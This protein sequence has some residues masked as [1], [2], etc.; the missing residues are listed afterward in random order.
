M[1]PQAAQDATILMVDDEPVNLQLLEQLLRGAGYT[2]VTSTTDP[3]RM[4]E[5]YHQLA[6][7]LVMLD[8]RMPH[9]DGFAVMR[10]LRL[11]QPQGSYL[12]ILMLT[13]E[14]STESKQRALS[15]GA[16]DFLHK[17]FDPVEVLLRI[18]NL[19][20]T[21]R[22]HTDLRLDNDLLE[23][24]IRERTAEIERARADLAQIAHAAAHE[25]VEPV[26]TV[27]IN[28]QFLAQ[29]LGQGLDGDAAQCL[30]YIVEGSTRAY[31]LLGDLLAI[32]EANATHADVAR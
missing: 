6:P 30:R 29:R 32:A 10:Q 18:A 5:L 1:I 28:V 27:R 16:T 11:A 7:D 25:L 12:P 2:R 26:R 19:L 14:V 22:L 23:Q 15:E 13:A 8:L 4:L 17:P 31:D 9:L 24:R 3:R 21:K 20:E